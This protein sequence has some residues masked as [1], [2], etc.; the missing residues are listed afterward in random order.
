[1]RRM[2]IGAATAAL[3]TLA[4]AAPVAAGEPRCSGIFGYPHG[5]HVIADYVTGI[6]SEALGGPGIQWP[7]AGLNAAGGAAMPG[8]PS[9]GH[10]VPPGASF[11]PL[12]SGAG[13]PG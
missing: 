5:Y 13:G 10:V 12:P 2:L 11:C 3:L 8:G 6:G 9:H 4:V 1:M 7:P